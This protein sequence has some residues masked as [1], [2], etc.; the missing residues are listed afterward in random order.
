MTTAVEAACTTPKI[1]YLNPFSKNSAHHRPIGTGALYAA[2][3]HPS[4]I[5]WFKNPGRSISSTRRDH[6]VSA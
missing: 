3:N 6:G 4:T 1:L 5:S 2:G